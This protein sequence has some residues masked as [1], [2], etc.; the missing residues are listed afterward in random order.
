M[1]AIYDSKLHFNI[2]TLGFSGAWCFIVF[3]KAWWTNECKIKTE[4][5]MPPTILLYRCL[6]V[7]VCLF[8]HVLKSKPIRQWPGWRSDARV[9]SYGVVWHRL[10]HNTQ[11]HFL[12]IYQGKYHK[13]IQGKQ[14]KHITI[15]NNINIYLEVYY[16]ILPQGGK[17]K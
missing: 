13:I 2:K 9:A 5:K 11:D 3:F 12:Q 17:E 7:S 16:Y 6:C 8:L 15:Y 14:V 10:T 4:A 1:D